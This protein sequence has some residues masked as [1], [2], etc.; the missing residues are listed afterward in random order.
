M[1][2]IIYKYREDHKMVCCGVH[3][4]VEHDSVLIATHVVI[5]KDE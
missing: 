5:V 4:D 3:C 1:Y 2:T